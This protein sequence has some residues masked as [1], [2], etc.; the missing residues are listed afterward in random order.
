MKP[1]SNSQEMKAH[2]KILVRNLVRTSG[3]L[4]RNS[5]AKLTGL[6]PS[7]VTIIVK[8]LLDEGIIHE[9]G[10]DKSTGGRKPVNLAL[11]ADAAGVS[12]LGLQQGYVVVGIVDLQNRM[13]AQRQYP[14]DTSRPEKVARFIGE[15]LRDL[16]KEA[17]FPYERLLRAGLASPGIIDIEQGVLERSVNLGWGSVPIRDLLQKELGVTVDIENVSNAAV[18]AHHLYGQGA[19][20]SN[21]VYI[22][23]SVGISAGVI[24]NG[25]IFGG[26][27][28]Y[29]CEVGHMAIDLEKGPVCN[30]GNRGCLESLCGLN[31]VLQRIAERNP[32]LAQTGCPRDFEDVAAAAR[33]GDSVTTEVL[34]ETGDWLGVAITNLIHLFHPEMVILGGELSRLSS[35][36]TD[37]INEVVN[38]RALSE[39]R[40]SVRIV[41]SDMP[42][43][44]L[45]GAAAIAL[46]KVF[47]RETVL[48]YPQ[49]NL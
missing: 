11:C 29:A 19:G 7:T 26:K 40:N 1:S 37:R 21:I 46:Q 12:A 42:D 41:V 43:P 10:C 27:G 25:R 44:A 47:A 24:M 13:V 5:L 3:P 28:G 9:V 6:S 39:F 38:R 2:N 16:S 31:A 14:A 32:G 49:S 30:C 15:R 23:L 33:A 18:L 36:L 22:T 17:G 48:A 45:K 34:N 35:A 20:H 4:S 8:D